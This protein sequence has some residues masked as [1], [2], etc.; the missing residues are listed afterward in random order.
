MLVSVQICFALFLRSPLCTARGALSHLFWL[1]AMA[2][3]K[4]DRVK[5]FVAALGAK[6]ACKYIESVNALCETLRPEKDGTK[7]L[8]KRLLVALKMPP[9]LTPA[10]W[11]AEGGLDRVLSYLDVRI[12]PD[13]NNL[14]VTR[15][16]GAFCFLGGGAVA[17]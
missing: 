16:R 8:Q 5:D 13:N 12:G 17:C 1:L 3:K 7:A 11:T 6:R 9:A 4:S 15:T 2:A 10:G 14:L